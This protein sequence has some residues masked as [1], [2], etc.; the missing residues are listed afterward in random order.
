MVCRSAARGGYYVRV[1]VFS[2]PTRIGSVTYGHLAAPPVSV[3]QVVD[4]WGGVVGALAGG[5]PREGSCWSG[6]HLHQE[7]YAGKGYACGA[8]R[9][10]NT[11]IGEHDWLGFVTGTRARGPKSY[12]P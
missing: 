10:S 5:L 2:G 1:A 4:R 12:C 3:G 7:A 8:R 9:S 11:A 6:P